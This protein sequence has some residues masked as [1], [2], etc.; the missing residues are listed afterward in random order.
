MRR[1]VPWDSFSTRFKAKY[2]GMVTQ[3]ELQQRFISLKQAGK[4]VDGYAAEFC[5]LNRFAPTMVATEPEKA[6]RF[7]QGLHLEILQLVEGHDYHT[8]DAVL[9]AARR[10]ELTQQRLA[11]RTGG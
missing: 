11:M 8:F 1:P 2:F 10:H 9:T 4:T 6:M 3:Y 7:Q 5:K